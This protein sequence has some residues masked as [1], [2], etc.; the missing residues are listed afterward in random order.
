MRTRSSVRFTTSSCIAATIC[1]LPR[2][3]AETRFLALR[4][5]LASMVGSVS[6][7]PTCSIRP[8]DFQR[9][10]IGA[11]LPSSRA[12]PAVTCAGHCARPPSNEDLR[13]S[14]HASPSCVTRRRLGRSPG[15]RR[16]RSRSRCHR[17]PRTTARRYR[18]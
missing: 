11:D 10:Q 3:R 13:S 14:R 15:H 2:S 18:S 8:R 1:R 17:S 6:C 12:G 4:C 5:S 7:E 16:S 9:K